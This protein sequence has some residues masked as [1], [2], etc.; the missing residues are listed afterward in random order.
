MVGVSGG[1]GIT[2]LNDLD[3]RSG[4]SPLY[5]VYVHELDACTGQP[6]FPVRLCLQGQALKG[7]WLL[8]VAH[9]FSRNRRRCPGHGCVESLAIEREGEDLHSMCRWHIRVLIGCCIM[10]SLVGVN[11]LELLYSYSK[12][13]LAV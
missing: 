6:G 5:C 12:N 11:R 13:S 2:Q 9:W 3:E 4:A 10:G 1:H 7:R 8:N